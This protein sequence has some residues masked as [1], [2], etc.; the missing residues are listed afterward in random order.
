MLLDPPAVDNTLAISPLDP[1]RR[2][3]RVKQE[4]PEELYTRHSGADTEFQVNPGVCINIKAWHARTA[5]DTMLYLV[6]NVVF[7]A[8]C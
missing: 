1:R 3:T 7:A 5:P 4:E 2:I 6:A 8:F